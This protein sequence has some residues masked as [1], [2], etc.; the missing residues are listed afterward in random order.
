MNVKNTITTYENV[1]RVTDLS[2]PFNGMYQFEIGR[3]RYYLDGTDVYRDDNGKKVKVGEATIPKE[4]MEE[5]GRRIDD[6]RKNQGLPTR[7]QE[8]SQRFFANVERIFTEFRG[9]G[10]YANLFWGDDELLKWRND[11]DRAFANAHLGIEYWT[12]DIC[13]QKLDGEQVGV[14]YAETPQGLAQVG[15]H[16]EATRTQPIINQTRGTTYIYKITF[17]VRN[18]DWEKDPRAPEHMFI[19]A[20]IRDGKS[21]TLFKRDINVTRGSSFGRAGTGERGAIVRESSVLYKEVCLTFD[22]I[23]LKWKI[24]K[25]EGGK[26]ILCNKIQESSGEPTRLPR[27]E[28][29]Q[30]E[31][32]INDF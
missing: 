32:E 28:A 30:P 14:A 21:V 31:E 5:L 3:Q 10:Y 6:L 26:F 25:K 15:A 17:Q 12:S 27:Q 24:D 2:S 8:A 22:K 23:P 16:I 19:N 9:L 20:I 18:G 11:V 4:R 1:R 13:D 29:A 7:R